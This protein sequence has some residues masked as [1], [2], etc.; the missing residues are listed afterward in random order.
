MSNNTINSFDKVNININN[1]HHN[2]HHNDLNTMSLNDSHIGNTHT[3]SES[4][5]SKDIADDSQIMKNEKFWINDPM[6]LFK[7]NNYYKILPNPNMNT[8][9][10][11]NALTRFFIYII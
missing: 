4:N 2:D 10:I 8:I 6:V 11:F 3:F 9:E 7:N 5:P 1:D